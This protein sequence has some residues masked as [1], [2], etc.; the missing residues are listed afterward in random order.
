MSNAHTPIRSPARPRLG[1]GERPGTRGQT[2]P[3]DRRPGRLT[4]LT[5][6]AWLVAALAGIA[7]CARSE[8]PPNLAG[9]SSGVASAQDGPAAAESGA[10][11]ALAEPAAGS[12]A[13]FPAGAAAPSAAADA[14]AQARGLILDG[15]YG[16]ASR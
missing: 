16:R 4:A 3:T 14:L 15:D 13:P 2:R 1:I 9:N 6:A 11:I 8:A 12:P 10:A 7:G 5:L